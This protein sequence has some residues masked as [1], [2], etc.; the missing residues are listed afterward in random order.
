MKKLILSAL[1]AMALVACQ[2]KEDSV[3]IKEAIVI[4]QDMK[5]VHVELNGML[6]IQ[7]ERYEAFVEMVQAS[8]DSGTMA[9]LANAGSVIQ[10]LQSDLTAWDNE[11]V[12]IPGYCFHEEGTA[13]EH[14][15]AEEARL[16]KLSDQEILDIQKELDI[17]LKEIEVKVRSL[18][19]K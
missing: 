17:K 7:Y 6:D 2:E 18:E 10:G 3:Q 19:Q 15:H 8:G 1:V 5:A 12:E 9:A 4:H 14:D 11:L 16:A 13:H